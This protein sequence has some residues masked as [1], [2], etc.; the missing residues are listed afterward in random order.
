M[1]FGLATLAYWQLSVVCGILLIG[2][3]GPAN[4]NQQTTGGAADDGH[5]HS[6]SHMAGPH[7]GHI[8][9]LGH[10]AYHA[11]WLHDDDTGLV[12]IYVLDS[13]MEE[14]VPIS[15]SEIT[16][17]VQ[18]GDTSSRHLLAA[19]EPSE[20]GQTAQFE[21]SNKSLIEALKLAGQGAD[22]I[23]RV[24]IGGKP[25]TGRFERDDHSGHNH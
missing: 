20:D 8:V 16:I 14:V 4:V 25:Y 17:D 9:E 7:G 12:T 13:A 3:N 11:E 21:L 1:R 23:I 24:E 18:I 6:H 22:A 5:N 19:V 2:C 10:E 15:A